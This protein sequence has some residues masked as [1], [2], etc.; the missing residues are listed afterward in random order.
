MLFLLAVG[1]LAGRVRAAPVEFDLPVQ[2]ADGALLAFSR[3]A[4][5]ELLF[6]SADLHQVRSAAVNGSYEPADALTRLLR[7]TGFAARSNGR[8]KF[9]VTPIRPPTGSLRGRLLAPDGTAARGLQVAIADPPLTAVT[10]ARGDFVF[11]ALRPGMYRLTATGPGY[12]PLQI[13]DAKVA[14]GRAETLE[15]QTMHPVGDPTRLEPF[16]VEG[17]SARSQLFDH[18]PAIGGPSAVTGNLDLRRTEDDALPYAIYDRDLIVRSG[19]VNLNEFIQRTVLDSDAGTRP[20]E[21]R[22]GSDI[23]VGNGQSQ[24]TFRAGS[25]NLT[26]RGYGASE[27]VV[28]V[29]GRRLPEVLISG[30]RTQQPDVNF[31]PLSLVQRVE[32]LPISASALYSGNAVGG[33]INIVLRPDIDLTEVTATYTNAWR[34]F[35]APQ[36]TI[37]L[38][39]GETLLGGALRVRLNATFTATMPATEAEL[40]H[41]QEALAANP[42]ANP[43]A[44]LYRATP[45]VRSADGTPLFGPGTPSFTSV[46]LGADGLGGAA[47]F[48]GREG[49]RS[50][51]LFQSPGGLANSQ[52]SLE[53]PYGRQQRGESYF[54]SATYDVTP[55]LQ[56]GL[57]GIYTH[58]VVNRGYN[59]FPGDLTLAAASPFNPFHRDLAV[60]LNEITSGLGEGYSEGHL[61]FSSV[62]LGVLLR[63]PR[64]WTVS[65][66]TQ[67]GHSLTR[68]RGLADVDS[69]RWQQLVDEGRYNPLRDTETQAAPA[70]FYDR[71]LIYYGGRDRFV[72]FGNYDALDS[73]LRITNSLLALPTGTGV[74]NFGGDYRRNHL[75]PSTTEQRFGDGSLVRAPIRWS[76]RTLQRFSVFGELQAPLVP[77]RWLP[78]WIREVQTD[79]AARYVAS[80]SSEESNLAPTGGLKVEFAG[81]FSLRGTVAT[82]NRLPPPDLSGTSRTVGAPVVGGGSEVSF[83]SVRDPQRNDE[84]NN[85][86]LA[87]AALNPNLRPEAAVTWTTGVLWRRGEVHQFRAAIDFTDTRKSGELHDLGEQEV[88]DLEALLPGRV[89]RAAP[90]PGDPFAVGPITSILTGG[91]NLAY[92]HS[93]NWSTMLDYAWTE[94]AGGRLRLYGQ[95]LYFQRYDVQVLPNTPQVDELQSPDSSAPGLLRHRVNFGAG[96]SNQDYGFGVD[97]HYFH[98]RLLP[99]RD[100]AAQGGDRIAPYWQFDAYLQSDLTRW[101]P[102]KRK[103]SR[104]GLQ[105]QLR[106]DNLSNAQPPRYASDPLGTG[107]QSYGEWRGRVYSVSVTAT[108]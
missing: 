32:V 30:T 52:N 108:F 45:N 62:V 59:I 100:W 13:T 83:V 72:T 17:R 61:D 90:A 51:S 11:G 26:L 102:G 73:A 23:D 56:L 77:A 53:F 81:G 57:D 19:V 87:S 91:F 42:T 67:Y 71:A 46:A 1:L 9:V 86:V 35:D 6:S 27:T 29:N 3:Q 94:C 88:V 44:G 21:Q 7:D 2:P 37:S 89:T 41:I 101:L 58:T 79:L 40:G 65:L 43:G 107:V 48:A 103:N 14:A 97:G 70:D 85:K 49:V 36:S 25:T 99:Q 95:W 84:V 31:I 60:S 5:V 55:W 50:L 106:I 63:L 10:N 64:D 12:Q 47:A 18:G 4:G 22:P 92:R 80:N 93:Q 66:D 16:V 39:H 28:L 24:G 78:D 104:F 15:T 96:W 69:A 76:G 74:V 38:Q 98:S 75:A 20:P 68:Y 105:G 82:S 8:G 54:G 34:G 33:V